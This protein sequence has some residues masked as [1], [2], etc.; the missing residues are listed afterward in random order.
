MVIHAF[1]I[2][3]SMSMLVQKL[4]DHKKAKDHKMMIRDYAWLMISRSSRSHS[5]QVKDTSQSLKSKITTSCLQDEVKKST[6]MVVKNEVVN[7]FPRFS[8]VFVVKL[9]TS[10]LINDFPYD[11]ID[12][13]IKDLDIK[14]KID[15]MMSDFLDPSRWKELSKETSGK[16]LP[17]G[18]GSCRKTFKPIASLSVKGKL[19]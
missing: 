7:D 16:I 4:Q 2:K 11:R 3:N 10:L 18:D 12:M 19:K 5:C 6:L 17:R 8:S 14:P 13:I 9:T 1:N 15:A